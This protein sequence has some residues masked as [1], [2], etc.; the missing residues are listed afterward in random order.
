MPNGANA[1]LIQLRAWLAQENV[2]S[3]SR[4]PPER[5]LCATLGVSRGELRKALDI[6]ESE[7]RV[8]R[9]V[10]KGTFVGIRPVDEIATLASVASSSSPAEVMRARLSIE[11][12]LA[13][14]A[15]LNATQA[16]LDQIKLCATAARQSTSWREYE[17]SDNRFHRAVAEASD[18]QVLLA[19]FDLLNTIRRT[20]V[21]SRGRARTEAPAADHHSFAEHD[22]VYNAIANRDPEGARR[23]MFDHLNSVQSELMQM[24]EAAQ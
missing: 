12:V 17:T 4:L 15:A 10:G 11:S 7:G 18:N 16:H 8:W 19:L 13:A 24:H 20:V 3:E 1:A 5:E 2:K 6:L 21:W 22:R 23:A 9:Q 14:E